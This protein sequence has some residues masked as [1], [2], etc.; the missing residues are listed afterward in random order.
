[1]CYNTYKTRKVPTDVCSLNKPL[2]I[3]LPVGYINRG[4]YICPPKTERELSV[5]S[6]QIKLNFLRVKSATH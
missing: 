2:I 6:G 3:K 1:M 4:I 5:L